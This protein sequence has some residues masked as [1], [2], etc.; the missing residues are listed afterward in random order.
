MFHLDSIALSKIASM[1]I[2]CPIYL[3]FVAYV[4]Y[5]PNKAQLEAQAMI[6]MQDD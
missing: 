3:G 2:F 4:F 6:P 1:A 5:K